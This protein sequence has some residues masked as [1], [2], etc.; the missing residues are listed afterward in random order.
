MSRNPA[1]SIA[2][3]VLVAFAIT[4]LAAAAR[5]DYLLSGVFALFF[6][7]YSIIRLPQLMGR[8]LANVPAHI[9]KLGYIVAFAAVALYFMY[10]LMR[11][12]NP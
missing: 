5:G 12:L 2:I 3:I 6:V 10:A 4:G 9:L 1:N 8:S 11:H 7:V